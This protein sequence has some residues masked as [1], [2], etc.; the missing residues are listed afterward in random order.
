MKR[1]MFITIEGID[2]AGKSTHLASIRA[3]LEA[4][5]A[6]VVE[7][8]EPGGTA[9][10]EKVRD[11]V[12]SGDA[13]DPLTEAMLV[14][15]ARRDHVQRVIRPALARGCVVLCDRFTDSSYAYQ[16]AGSGVGSFMLDRLEAMACLGL[17]VDLTLWF[18][19][20]AAEAARRRASARRA[21]RFESETLAY[22]ERVRAGYLQRATGVKR[23]VRVDANKSIAEVG[24]AVLAALKERGW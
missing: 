22:F 23:I 10:A 5:G 24:Q 2:G 3:H 14:F 17:T 18:D 4:H 19:V 13:Y 1:P 11:M 8:R 20:D 21:D 16:G 15:A 12:L 9:L 6:E 7:T